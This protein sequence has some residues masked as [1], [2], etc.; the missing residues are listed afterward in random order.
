MQ[1]QIII[2]PI[3]IISSCYV[4]LYFLFF[5][6]SWF[7]GFIYCLT[8]STSRPIRLDLPV[9]KGRGLLSCGQSS[10]APASGRL[11]ILTTTFNWVNYLVDLLLFSLLVNLGLLSFHQ[12]ALRTH[13]TVRLVSYFNNYLNMLC[14][15]DCLNQTSMAFVTWDLLEWLWEKEIGK[16]FC[17]EV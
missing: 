14:N 5:L 8:Q 16:A 9:I 10:C 2:N 15:P 7:S 3:E 1:A 17:I 12:D 6:F 11:S 13:D 4:P